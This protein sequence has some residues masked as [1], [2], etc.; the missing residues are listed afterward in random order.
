MTA[1]ITQAAHGSMKEKQ[2]MQFFANVESM[3][4]IPL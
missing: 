3:Q 1:L 2:G 4:A